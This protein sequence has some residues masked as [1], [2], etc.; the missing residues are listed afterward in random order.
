MP[1]VGYML[2]TGNEKAAIEN[3]R[4]P[5]SDRIDNANLRLGIRLV[6]ISA[7]ACEAITS[8]TMAHIMLHTFPFSGN[9]Q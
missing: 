2:S 7:N 9:P 3:D 6:I 4:M 8:S 1:T 5:T